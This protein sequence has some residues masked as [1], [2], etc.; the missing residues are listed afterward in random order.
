MIRKLI[1]LTILL[2]FLAACDS[3]ER[4]EITPVESERKPL[5][6]STAAVIETTKI[7]SDP[8][9][10][11]E[12]PSSPT[13]L[14]TNI[15]QPVPGNET[16]V[17]EADDR[18]IRYN[19]RFDF[20][21]PKSPAFD[22]SATSIDF[23]FS[24]KSLTIFLQDGRNS[25]NV[26]LDDRRQ[27]LKTE[28]GVKEYLIAENLA[29][30]RHHF[31][32]S[33][34]TEA[35]VGAAEFQ[36]LKIT[37]GELEQTSPSAERLIEFIGDSI[38]TGY[39]N[40]GESPDCWFTPDTQNADNSYA[41]ITAR[42]LDAGYTL[43]ALSGL[44]VIRNLRAED[45]ASSETAIQFVD[46]ALGLNPFVLWPNDRRVP[47]V[48]VINLGTNDY[49]SVPFPDEEEFITAYMELMSAIR[50]RYPEA[51]IFAVAGPLMLD[52]APLLIQSA[53]QRFNASYNDDRLQYVKIENNLEPNA[54]DFGCDFHPN[55][56]GHRKIAAQLAPVIARGLGW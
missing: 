18:R 26:I 19:G 14:P 6:T 12:P 54:E 52:P 22:W 55:V 16:V 36:G 21:D 27:V 24:G 11:M 39:G 9:P 53:V 32:L 44:G 7:A 25:Y 51:F 40:E 34:R 17:F 41:A 10:T 38:T 35:Y 4:T 2:L 45:P 42:E 31:T 15:A 28:M 46:R 23:V 5:S 37:G 20:Q 43:I 8:L 29:P 47:Q 1:S 3:I 13:P 56:N 49:S 50:S 33:K 48:V 30:G